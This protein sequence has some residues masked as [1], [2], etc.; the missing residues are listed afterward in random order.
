L[1]PSALGRSGRRGAFNG[2]FDRGSVRGI[3]EFEKPLVG[4][5]EFLRLASEPA[6]KFVGP[7]QGTARNVPT[8]IPQ[9][10]E[11]LRLFQLRLTRGELLFGLLA[12]GDVA[13][14]AA[15]A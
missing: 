5:N 3:K 2:G 12:A 4:G 13:R 8:P 15:K 14:D 1:P 11:S 6:V 7:I 9:P 10:G